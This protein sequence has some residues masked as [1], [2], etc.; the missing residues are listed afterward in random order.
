MSTGAH[1]IGV[2]GPGQPDAHLQQLAV[3]VGRLLAEAG[4]TL[5]CGGLGGVMEAACQGAKEAGGLT[6]GILPGSDAAVANAYVQIPIATGLGEARNVVLVN[7]VEAVIAVGKGYGTLSEICPGPA[8]RNSRGPSGKLGSGRRRCR[9]CV[10]AR[11]GVDR[12]ACISVVRPRKR[13]FQPPAGLKRAV[14][15]IFASNNHRR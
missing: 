11:G 4:C 3:E 14:S 7:S 1:R 8:S 9:G 12:P 2:I 6:V 13:G 5:Y 15:V 10:A